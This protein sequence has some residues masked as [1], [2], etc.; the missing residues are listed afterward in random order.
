MFKHTEHAKKQIKTAVANSWKT[1]D[2]IDKHRNFLQ[3]Y[4][5]QHGH[6]P[7]QSAE[8]QQKRYI[9][10]VNS[11]GTRVYGGWKGIRCGWLLSIKTQK[12]EYYG[13]SYELNRMLEMDVDDTV[14]SWTKQH[15]FLVNY[16]VNGK[17][18]KYKP[19]FYIEYENGV[20][21]I[22]EIKGYVK[23]EDIQSF[24]AKVKSATEYFPK[25]GIEYLVNFKYNLRNEVVCG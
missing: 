11:L 17:T 12:N 23:P 3:E 22:E 14:V 1:T 15:P 25:L 8:A 16:V 6:Y 5:E 19:D 4:K 20:R 2:R 18:A 21:V 10:L 24:C 7:M 9:S 13:S